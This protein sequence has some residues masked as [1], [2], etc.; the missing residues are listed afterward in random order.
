ML[1]EIVAV[2]F[3][4]TGVMSGSGE[5]NVIVDGAAMTLPAVMANANLLPTGMNNAATA[6]R[7][8]VQSAARPTV[9]TTITRPQI[10]S[11]G[12]IGTLLAGYVAEMVNVAVAV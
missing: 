7:F 4:L 1:H 6:G 9:E 12:V 11:R 5:V 3:P 8:A 10:A 2:V